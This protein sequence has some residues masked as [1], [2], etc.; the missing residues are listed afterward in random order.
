MGLWTQIIQLGFGF[1]ALVES[2]ELWPRVSSLS[3]R[4]NISSDK[5]NVDQV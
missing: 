5:L 3:P 1:W 2:V 4:R